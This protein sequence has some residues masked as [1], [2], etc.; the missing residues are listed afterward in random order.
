[1]KKCLILLFVVSGAVS[2][3][4]DDISEVESINETIVAKN[5]QML[6]TNEAFINSSTENEIVATEETIVNSI[7]A[8]NTANAQISREETAV[9]PTNT[10]PQPTATTAANPQPAVDTVAE[11]EIVQPKNEPI[12]FTASDGLE[13][14]GTYS[15]PGGSAPFPAVILLHMLG[16]NRQIWVQ[17]GLTDALRLQGYAVLT[18]DMRGH[19][20]TS[21][22]NDWVLARED[23]AMI[24]DQFVQFPEVDEEKTAVIGASV[25]SNMA[26]ALGVDKTAVQTTILLSPGL[27]YVG[28]TTDDLIDAYGNRPLLIVASQE[29]SYSADSS[30]TLADS[31]TSATLQLYDGAG[32]GTTMLTREPALSELIL[33]WLNT[34]LQT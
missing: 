27:D 4:N 6:A 2:C 34:H 32:H 33:D 29:D 30:Q 25:G 13:I 20:E 12:S 1:M 26:L 9:S 19:G 23:L 10:P 14:K 11:P 18:I 17:T 7:N 28:V 21:G 8:T 3:I 15:T 24:Y 31:A 5:S 22:S 16:S